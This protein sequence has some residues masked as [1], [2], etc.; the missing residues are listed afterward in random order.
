MLRTRRRRSASAAAG[1]RRRRAASRRS[2]SKAAPRVPQAPLGCRDSSRC[3]GG[4]Y[5]PLWCPSFDG[6]IALNRL[7]RLFSLLVLAVSLSLAGVSSA[8]ATD[9]YV[10]TSGSDSSGDGSASHPLAIIVYAS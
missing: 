2:M 10:S 9:Y 4:G 3:Q 1:R 8:S 5:E 6:G 7:N